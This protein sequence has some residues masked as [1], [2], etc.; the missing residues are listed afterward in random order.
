M[1][2][3]VVGHTDSVGGYAFNLDL[4]QRRAAAV[5]AALATRYG[6]GSDRL[7]PIGVSFASPVA[8]NRTDEGRSRNRRVELVDQTP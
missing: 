6:I 4:S 5:V 1:K 8:S 3:L 7:T 2:L